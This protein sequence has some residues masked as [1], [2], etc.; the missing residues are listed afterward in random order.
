MKK[1]QFKV[2]DLIKDKWAASYKVDPWKKTTF[3][4]KIDF[5]IPPMGFIKNIK[6]I[7]R[8]KTQII[9]SIKKKIAYEV[10]VAEI[11]WMSVKIPE[12]NAQTNSWELD[13]YKK[14]KIEMDLKHIVLYETYYKNF[15][16]RK[17]KKTT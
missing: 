11:D 3:D 13:N 14:F 1:Q 9:E 4:V 5:Y 6:K 2:G 8:Y 17:S 7:T 10:E 15:L 16:R 12:I